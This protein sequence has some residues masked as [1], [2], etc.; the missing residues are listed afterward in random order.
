MQ[1][2]KMVAGKYK[3]D[4]HSKNKKLKFTTQNY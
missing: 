4:N 3:H 1:K 2:I